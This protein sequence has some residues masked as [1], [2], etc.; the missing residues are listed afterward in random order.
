MVSYWNLSD[1]KSPQVF[2][3]LLSI[4]ADLNNA[5]ISM[6]S[7]RPLISK[8]PSPCTNHLVIVPKVLIKIG[9]TVTFMF[10]NFFQFSSKVK[11]LIFL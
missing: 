8:S 1:I 5:V 11:V 6:V 4:L 3:T 2:R 9:I 10:H 7:T